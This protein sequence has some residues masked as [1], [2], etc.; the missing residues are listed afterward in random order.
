[1]EDRVGTLSVRVRSDLDG[2]DAE[3]RELGERFTRGVIERVSAILEARAPGRVVFLR[4][5]P[6][7]WSISEADAASADELARAAEQV[8][9]AIEASIPPGELLPAPD[10]AAAVF[11]DEPALIAS[12]VLARARARVGWFHAGVLRSEPFDVLAERPREVARAVLARLAAHEA[13]VEVLAAA[14]AQRTSLER[15]ARAIGED[16][17]G[18]PVAGAAGALT[19]EDAAIVAAL[20]ERIAAWP[21]LDPAARAIA[22]YGH[23]AAAATGRAPGAI[24][25]IAAWTRLALAD[26]ARRSAATSP[27]TGTEGDVATLDAVT[28][29]AGLFYLIAPILELA[30]A[31]QLWQACLPEGAL[32]ARALSA[33]VPPG[34]AGDPALAAL[35]GEPLAGDRLPV[36]DH[37]QAHE[38][39]NAALA[40]LAAALPRGGRAALPVGHARFIEHATGR[41]LIA[42]AL[43]APFALFAW[44]A[45]SLAD[46][47]AGLAALLARWPASTPLH[48]APSLIELDRSGRIRHGGEPPPPF[49]VDAPT[50]AAVAVASVVT[51]A[52]CQLVAS[53]L[54]DLVDTAP[55]WAAR[56]LAGEARLVRSPDSLEV[57]RPADA[58]DLDLRRAGIDRDPGF[59]PWL[60][61][62]VRLRFED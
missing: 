30:I 13:L 54:D 45:A 38:I 53:R 51:G 57:W 11:D 9:A 41:L 3:L 31:E 20:G 22:A 14:R 17:A 36:I 24:D 52:P 43:D 28:R 49:V 35:A 47:M 40:S 15:L 56:R 23:A 44:P 7:R 55:A 10:A 4:T 29:H 42:T 59:V 12:A 32:I 50:A 62:T 34:D 48:G 60:G 46:A 2:R 25:R 27:A 26:A 18:E 6:I 61:C 39:A 8:A 5:L 33:L 58:V 37:A 19:G 1:V 16:A 21:A